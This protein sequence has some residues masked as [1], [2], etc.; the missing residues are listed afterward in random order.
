MLILSHIV[1][2]H[3]FFMVAVVIF[4]SHRHRNISM[5]VFT[6]KLSHTRSRDVMQSRFQKAEVQWLQRNDL[7]RLD[8]A[9]YAGE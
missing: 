3:D 8:Y 7:T 6:V 2:L 4:H 9:R 5:S 1:T